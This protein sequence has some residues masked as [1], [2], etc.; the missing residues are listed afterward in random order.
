MADKIVVL[1]TDAESDLGAFV[2]QRLAA[3]GYT[4]AASDIH[5]IAEETVRSSGGTFATGAI[6][7]V[8]GGYSCVK[9]GNVKRGFG[10]R[11]NGHQGQEGTP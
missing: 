9:A 7:N 6:S 5:L 11:F 2:A 8:T 4:V 1:V 10:H 3:D